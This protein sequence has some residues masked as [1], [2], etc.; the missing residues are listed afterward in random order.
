MKQ[1]F[2]LSVLF[3]LNM[4]FLCAQD[5]QTTYPVYNVSRLYEPILKYICNY[6]YRDTSEKAYANCAFFVNGQFV[7]SSAG[8]VLFTNTEGNRDSAFFMQYGS[9]LVFRQQ[10]Y[11]R[12]FPGNTLKDVLENVKGREE[13]TI[14]YEVDT[15]DNSVMRG[16]RKTWVNGTFVFD[17]KLMLLYTSP[18]G[19][20][21]RYVCF[22]TARKYYKYPNCYHVFWNFGSYSN[23]RY[24]G[25][26][27]YLKKVYRNAR[28]VLRTAYF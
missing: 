18:S 23:N 9:M 7:E 20:P 19:P 6:P 14:V 5:M 4:S 26:K 1:L 28:K 27:K 8:F 21:C 22:Y 10:D 12:M 13:I 24:Y 11:N 25:D 15:R 16:D 3:L 17:S 2:C